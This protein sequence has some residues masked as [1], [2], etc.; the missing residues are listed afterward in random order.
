MET[1]TLNLKEQKRLLV[2]NRINQGKLNGEQGAELLGLS[3]RHVR[4]M[5][6]AYREDGAGALA[7]GNRGRESTRRIEEG[8]RSRIVSLARADYAGVNQ[9]HFT[10]LLAE[11][12]QLPVSRSTVRRVLAEAGIPSP[13]KHRRRRRHRLRRERYAQEGMLLQIDGSRHD[14]LQ[15]RGPRMTLLA[16][17]DDATGKIL[18]AVFRQ[19][20]DAQGYFLLLEQIVRRYG[21]PLAIYRD[22]HS[23][24]ETQKQEPTLEE[25]LRG[26]SGSTQFGR[27]LEELDIRSIPAYSPQAKGRV[28]RLFGTLQDRLVSELRLHQVS[29]LEDA[30]QALQQFLPAFNQ[31]FALQAPTPG[32]V[33][34]KLPRTMKPDSVFCFK[35]DRTVAADNT[36]RI[37]EDRIQLQSDSHRTHYVQAR[38]QL[39]IRMDG[40]IAVYYKNRCLTTRPAPPEAPLIR[41][42]HLRSKALR[43]APKSARKPLP[44]KNK[45]PSPFKPPRSYR[46]DRKGH[47]WKRPYLKMKNESLY[48][49]GDI[50]TEHL[51]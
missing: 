29:T 35:F 14:W 41:L 51:P 6:A 40:H 23:I 13:R 9:Q 46:V 43:D 25:Q 24:F 47:P 27:L 12:E 15:A 38:V 22:R 31:R 3:V 28:E 21:R 37:G 49:A 34:R 36:V 16:G 45:Q 26:S 33:Y 39:H 18:G 1:V 20:E 10:E 5:L 7:H 48:P 32:R 30:Q 8:Q 2:L 19:Q 50:F 44:K 11:R 17:V 42:E 4:R